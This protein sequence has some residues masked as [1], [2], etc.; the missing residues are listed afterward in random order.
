MIMIFG[1]KPERSSLRRAYP[2]PFSIVSFRRSLEHSPRGLRFFTSKRRHD[3]PDAPHDLS[4]LPPTHNHRNHDSPVGP[5]RRIPQNHADLPSMARAACGDLR[6]E[7]R[8]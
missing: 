4:R 1:C 2:P 7:S 5:D 6:K 8:S 3:Q